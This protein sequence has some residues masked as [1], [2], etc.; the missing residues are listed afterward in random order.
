MRDSFTA[1]GNEQLRALLLPVIA[2]AGF[3]RL[4]HQYRRGRIDPATYAA[5]A[6]QAYRLAEW[7]ERAHEVAAV[8]DR[9]TFR[10]VEQDDSYRR[11]QVLQP[12][13]GTLHHAQWSEVMASAWLDGE[14]VGW[15]TTGGEVVP[16]GADDLLR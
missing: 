12:S 15:L 5:R 1:K 8:Y 2:R 9:L 14:Q 7:W 11:P 13:A 6:E 4:W 16:A 3:D 10:P